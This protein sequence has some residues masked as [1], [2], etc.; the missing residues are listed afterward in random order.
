[1]KYFTNGSA[2]YTSPGVYL[3]T[4]IVTDVNGAK[5]TISKAVSIYK[6]P[7]VSFA[8]DKTE[9]CQ[10]DPVTFTNN[11]TIG[12]AGI[13]SWTWDFGDGNIS[14]LRSQSYAYQSAGEYTVKLIATDSNGCTADTLISNFVEVKPRSVPGM[15]F[16]TTRLCKGPAIIDFTNTTT[17]A[18]SSTVWKFSDGSGSILRNTTKAF[19]GNG[20]L[21]VKLI[22]THPSG[23]IDSIE[24]SG[25]IEIAPLVPNFI[26]DTTQACI[27][28]ELVLRQVSTPQFTI[29]TSY[30]W[31][32]P[33]GS[34]VTGDTLLYSIASQSFNISLRVKNAE[35][36]ST[37][38]KTIVAR[39]PPVNTIVKSHDLACG[40]NVFFTFSL[41]TA[42]IDSFAWSIDN[43]SKTKMENVVV[44]NEEGN[45]VLRLFQRNKFG[46][47]AEYWDTIPQS[48]PSINIS[49]DTAGCV[50]YN[51]TPNVIYN[52]VYPIDSVLWDLRDLN[53]SAAYKGATTPV[54]SV[55]DTGAFYML[56]QMHD[57]LGCV[58]NRIVV[59]EGGYKPTAS[60]TQD[61]NTTCNNAIVTFTNTSTPPNFPTSFYWEV[62]PKNGE[63]SIW[64][65]LI[66]NLPDQYDI[67]HV[68]SHFGC[69]DTATIDTLLVQGPYLNFSVLKTGCLESIRTVETT[70]V[71]ADSFW[72]TLNGVFLG[73]DTV[74]QQSFKPNDTLRGYA[75]NETTGCIDS[76]MQIIRVK[77]AAFLDWDVRASTCAPALI[78]IERLDVN[79][80]SIRWYNNNKPVQHKEKVFRTQ[81]KQGGSLQIKLVGYLGGNCEITLDTTIVVTGPRVKAF[82]ANRSSCF[83]FEYLLIDSFWADTG[84]RYW[85]VGADTIASDSATTPYTYTA[86]DDG[87][88]DILTIKMVAQTDSCFSMQQ[89]NYGLSI[90]TFRSELKDSLLGCYD[91]RYTFLFDV[92]NQK[93]KEIKAYHLENKG[94]TYSSTKPRLSI[95]VSLDGSRD[96]FYLSIETIDGCFSTERRV[97]KKN[98]PAI[99]A[100]FSSSIQEATCPPLQVQFRD[101]S[102]SILGD[103]VQR[104]WKLKG[105]ALSVLK[106]PRT[107]LTQ[108]GAYAVQLK[109]ID[110]SGC[111]DSIRLDS[112]IQI[113]G[114]PIVAD[115]GSKKLCHGDSIYLKVVE[116]EAQFFEWDMGDGTVV[117]G[118]SVSYR[119]SDTGAYN[120]TILVSDSVC[121]YAVTHD[122]ETTIAAL[123]EVKWS[124]EGLCPNSTSTFTD[125]STGQNK[126]INRWW[127]ING[128]KSSLSEV[129][130]VFEASNIN[131]SLKIEDSLGC[132]DSISETLKLY[133]VVA[134]FDWDKDFYCQGDS[135]FLRSTSICDTSLRSFLFS[136]NNQVI[137]DSN[138]VK[139]AALQ[140]GAYDVQLLVV[141]DV[142]CRDTI[143]KKASIRVAGSSYYSN[144]SIQYVSVEENND[145]YVSW[146][147]DTMG[148]FQ[149][150]ELLDAT[151]NVV[152]SSSVDDQTSTQ[153]SSLSPGLNAECLRIR[154]NSGCKQPLPASPVH[155][156]IKTK[157][158]SLL[159]ARQIS[160]TPYIGWDTV[161]SYIVYREENGQFVEIDVVPSNVYSY[162]DNEHIACDKVQKYK[163][164][165]KNNFTSFSDT[166]HVLPVW[167]YQVP[168]PSLSN[169]SVTDAEE[170]VLELD[171]IS[172]P[173][174]PLESIVIFRDGA[175]IYTTQNSISENYID[176]YA[177]VNTQSY[178]YAA[179]QI[180][181]CGAESDFSNEVHSIYLRVETDV[182]LFPKLIWT[183]AQIWDNFSYY[184]IMKIV[185][186]EMSEVQVVQD[187]YDTTFVDQTSDIECSSQV[188]YVVL[189]VSEVAK[190]SWS[191]KAC[192]D[193][194]S[195]LYAPNAVTPNGDLIN[196]TYSPRGMY[197]AKYRL[198]I[199]NS[200]GEQVFLTD[201]CMQEWDCT[202][203]GKP[204]SD[205]TYFY[206]LYA[207]GAD[208][209]QHYL[210]GIIHVLR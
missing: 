141:N 95:D 53:G 96:T 168:A 44:L 38:T 188:C 136:V 172:G 77:S 143:I 74:F 60:F 138:E 144:A 194:S 146:W 7:K 130:Q 85:V 177:D 210:N 104:Q 100:A 67:F 107:I 35:C 154:V 41:D 174:V 123:P 201:K 55:T 129:K 131:A 3:V 124:V 159:M 132:T 202:Y 88:K 72:Y 24:R 94:Q 119:Y 62:G 31:T 56:A 134:D 32:L 167:N 150:Y 42:S 75:V 116:G 49:P 73:A 195:R 43:L 197:I 59:L 5:D 83:P 105:E 125:K 166:C 27:G 181:V 11:T 90:V 45:H 153:L 4:L 87:S 17:P 65:P 128:Q 36:T 152:W 76:M 70:V 48:I 135:V 185:N 12:D 61:I 175:A 113:G 98:R 208:G 47:T 142:G 164:S 196:D 2:I 187:Q 14:P 118:D 165:A 15:S 91:S 184:R 127:N 203:N 64:T 40:P 157:G 102:V 81:M 86:S 108:P 179:K 6:K 54:L 115:F 66:K 120:I 121:K 80:D 18:S 112:F 180:D 189:A 126:L 145:V 137:G 163:V 99:Q 193:L 68:V 162:I 10:N 190:E 106:N 139:Y 25:D 161:Q 46:C 114:Q 101:E 169:V 26:W 198:T 122:E 63:T 173:Y 191:N 151:N 50:P 1:M 183:Q 37:V 57:S 110:Q 78:E 171:T 149:S 158:K 19:S 176:T 30:T 33:D 204:V 93:G 192:G 9:A 182:S 84:D 51:Y 29:P 147:G 8:V 133:P 111:E 58:H 205:G 89:Y 52:S 206:T 69:K 117:R 82:V 140:A 207:K 92:L 109:V 170:I 16:P 186:G 13:S 39:T 199:Y 79:M 148:L 71:D 156:T 20:V 22:S 97:I 23:C 103:V 28:D 200:W 178:G 209:K 160:W 155:C 34:K 21:S